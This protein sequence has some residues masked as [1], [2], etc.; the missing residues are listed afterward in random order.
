MRTPPLLTN[1]LRGMKTFLL[2][3]ILST[4]TLLD[5]VPFNLEYSWTDVVNAAS[6]QVTTKPRQSGSCEK[7]QHHGLL[8]TRCSALLT[9]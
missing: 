7:H 6:N 8:A 4:T 2:C 1:Q 5:F 3:V 9:L